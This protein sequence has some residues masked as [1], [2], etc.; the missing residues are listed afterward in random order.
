MPDYK[1]YAN[2]Q[3]SRVSEI[4]GLRTRPNS[5]SPSGFKGDLG[6]TD[7]FVETKTRTETY[8]Y[9]LI[10]RLWFEKLRTQAFSMG[11]PIAVL[12]VSAGDDQDYAFVQPTTLYSE[13]FDYSNHRPPDITAKCNKKEDHLLLDTIDRAIYKARRRNFFPSCKYSTEDMSEIWEI[14]YLEDF[15]EYYNKRGNS[16]PK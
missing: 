12:V 2:A 4:M 3:D 13:G 1:K 7:I 9:L 15:V 5:G 8:S 10:Q 6:G 14:M 16:K 11:K